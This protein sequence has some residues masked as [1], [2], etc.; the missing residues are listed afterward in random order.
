MVLRCSTMDAILIPQ[1]VICH[2]ELSISPLHQDLPNMNQ[3]LTCSF[4]IS[5]EELCIS[6]WNES[7]KALLG[8]HADEIIGIKISDLL[9]PSTSDIALQ[10]LCS[11][12]TQLG[13]ASQ[14]NVCLSK[15]DGSYVESELL[16]IHNQTFFGGNSALMLVVVLLNSMKEE[17]RKLEEHKLTQQKLAEEE[18]RR[19]AEIKQAAQERELTDYLCHEL[20]NQCQGILSC[21]ELA[22]DSV[23]KAQSLLQVASSSASSSK[24]PLDNL[25][26]STNSQLEEA[27][28]HMQTMS[29]CVNHQRSLVDETLNISETESRDFRLNLSH[30]KP[31][32]LATSVARLFRATVDKKKL[33]LDIT[34]SSDC[35]D[36]VFN[37]AG[38][39]REVIINLLSNSIKWTTEG[40]IKIHISTSSSTHLQVAVEDTGEG[41]TQ[42]EIS[43]LFQRFSHSKSSDYQKIGGSGLGLLITKN[44]VSQMGG[45]ISV[46]SEK[47]K[48]S[49]FTFTIAT[50]MRNLRK[51][52][53]PFISFHASS[54]IISNIEATPSKR[55]R[56]S[57]SPASESSP[58]EPLPSQE[59]HQDQIAEPMELTG[60]ILVVDNSE[61]SRRILRQLLSKF[62]C[63]TDMAADGLQAVQAF[64]HTNFDAIIMDL[65]MPIMNGVEAMQ[66]IREREI[67]LQRALRTPIVVLSGSKTDE[68]EKRKL[69]D[70]GADA[71]LTKPIHRAELFQTLNSLL[72]APSF[73]ANTQQ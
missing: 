54:P 62:G 34:A 49:V 26:S 9:H 65:L 47:K 50:D 63:Q 64:N 39:L 71:V 16:F 13:T 4:C 12:A 22:V 38:R 32:T 36:E 5:V 67:T 8:Y 68:P 15:R 57:M 10:R 18:T 61:I 58:I 55:R 24:S 28:M 6:T 66:S 17:K 11:T 43:T 45:S 44:L 2:Q 31:L 46:A 23:N 7:A 3:N 73:T 21:I 1:E 56:T 20:R 53:E 33:K 30:F 52:S 48:G 35:P 51:R 72:G 40:V 25:L 27:K 60:N 37:D 70:A 19:R 59:V 14:S 42:E 41:M 69:I 29:E